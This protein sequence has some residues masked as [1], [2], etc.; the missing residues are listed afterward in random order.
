MLLELELPK[1]FY[2][3]GAGNYLG[4]SMSKELEITYGFLC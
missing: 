4:I 1:D 3:N 2:V